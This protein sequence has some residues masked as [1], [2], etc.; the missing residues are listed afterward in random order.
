[1]NI[2]AG[3]PGPQLGPKQRVFGVCSMSRE[4]RVTALLKRS[5]TAVIAPREQSEEGGEDLVA[6]PF[7]RVVA[8]QLQQSAHRLRA[9]GSREET[10]PLY[11]IDR[12]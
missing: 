5:A 8:D 4:P 9:P 7:R 10:L 1:M 2:P 3:G 12:V 11:G 6:H